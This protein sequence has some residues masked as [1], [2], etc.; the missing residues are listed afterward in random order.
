MATAAITDK[1]AAAAVM[2][3]HP[4]GELIV[5]PG[6]RAQKAVE[7][8]RGDRL[9]YDL[10]TPVRRISAHN[11][12][13]L[14][15]LSDLLLCVRRHGSTSV[16]SHPSVTCGVYDYCGASPAMPSNRPRPLLPGR[17]PAPY[18]LRWCRWSCSNL[19]PSKPYQASRAAPLAHAAWRPL[20]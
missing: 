4:A 15:T 9:V 3:L 6:G 2:E 19:G 1:Q 13:N 11:V 16:L 8:Q 7:W 20:P 17:G 18:A 5:I 14:V 12:S 10:G